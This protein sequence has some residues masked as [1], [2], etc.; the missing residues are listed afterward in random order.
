MEQ[1]NNIIQL[2]ERMQ[3]FLSY[4]LL[5]IFIQILLITVILIAMVIKYVG[6]LIYKYILLPS[7]PLYNI[8]I[9]NI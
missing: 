3:S 5:I 4:I 7:D 6:V 1:R 8:P 2:R 9:Y